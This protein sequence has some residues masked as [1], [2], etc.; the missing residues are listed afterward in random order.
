MTITCKW[1]T[2]FSSS[3][4]VW[5]TS[6]VSHPFNQTTPC[7]TSFGLLIG[8][9]VHVWYQWC[10]A[11]T[12]PSGGIRSTLGTEGLAAAWIIFPYHRHQQPERE[13][14]TERERDRETHRER[15]WSWKQIKTWKEERTHWK[16]TSSKQK[17]IIT[18]VNVLFLWSPSKRKWMRNVNKMHSFL[19][20]LLNSL[21]LACEGI[22]FSFNGSINMDFLR[23]KQ[24]FLRC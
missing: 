18:G 7:L 2:V 14:E 8:K 9:Y 20:Q 19:I 6:V 24:C 13:T 4:S 3:L 23:L 1:Q 21:S 22:S 11:L 5:L 15:A 12:P 10:G 17:N 16:T